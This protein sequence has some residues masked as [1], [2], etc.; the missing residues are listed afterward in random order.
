MQPSDCLTTGIRLP[1]ARCRPGEI[2][3]YEATT[4]SL[5][6]ALNWASSCNK[7]NILPLRAA[8]TVNGTGSVF[9]LQSSI[10]NL[11]SPILS[12]QLSV[13]SV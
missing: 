3:L 10:L 4:F 1:Y 2:D 13:F 12:L 6:H 8:S 7:R 11:H 5:N 9:T